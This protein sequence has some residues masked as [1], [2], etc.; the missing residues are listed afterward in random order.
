M[1]TLLCILTV[2][3]AGMALQG[4][5]LA[6]WSTAG[7]PATEYAVISEE[8]NPDVAVPVTFGLVAAHGGI[9]YLIWV[10]CWPCA[11]AYL[12]FSGIYTATRI[13]LDE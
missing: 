4:C 10:A 2:G 12:G 13:G 3:M 6:L 11:V 1:K 9:T 5:G 8:E 7:I